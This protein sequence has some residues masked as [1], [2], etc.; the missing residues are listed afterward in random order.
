[1]AAP[2]VPNSDAGEEAYVYDFVG[3]L[4]LPL[5]PTAS[6]RTDVKAAFLPVHTLKD[7]G[8]AGKVRVMLEK[9]TPVLVTDGL[10]GSLPGD[11]RNNKSLAVLNV[12]GE[13]KRL[14]KLTREELKPIRERLLAPFGLRFDAPNKVALY[15]M[16]DDCVAVENFNVCATDRCACGADSAG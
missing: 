16:G 9:G 11:V 10:A 5:V 3:M 15:L 4:G 1:V 6:I 7:P 14:L 8:W 12:G 2:K 13:P